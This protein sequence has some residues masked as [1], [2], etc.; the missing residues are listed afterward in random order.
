MKISKLIEKL[1]ELEAQHGD[2]EVYAYDENADIWPVEG[3]GVVFA[4]EQLEG[5]IGAMI[6]S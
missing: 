2:V 5:T 1:A 6:F 4:S 3:N